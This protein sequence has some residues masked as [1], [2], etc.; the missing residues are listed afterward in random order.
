MKKTILAFVI[1]GIVNGA[2]DERGRV[3]QQQQLA[4]RPKARGWGRGRERV[5]A[6]AEGGGSPLLAHHRVH[7]QHRLRLRRPG[8]RQRQGPAAPSL[9]AR[10]TRTSP[11]RPLLRRSRRAQDDAGISGPV[12]RR[13]V[14]ERRPRLSRPLPDRARRHEQ[15]PGLLERARAPAGHAAREH[16]PR[17]RGVARE[18]R[19]GRQVR[20]VEARS[21][22]GR[23]ER[24]LRE[25]GLL[26]RR[27]R[28]R[29]HRARPRRVRELRRR[30]QPSERV[31][32]LCR[33]RQVDAR[34]RRRAPQRPADCEP[35][36][37]GDHHRPL[38][39]RVH[40]ALGALALSSSMY[41]RRGHPRGRRRVLA[42]RISQRA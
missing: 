35:L 37:A 29:G 34:R 36:A 2:G 16:A 8:G 39:G 7:R 9:S 4:G 25:S 41:A 5:E 12:Q 18:P 19:A 40:G 27:Q 38:A 3:L 23:R 33:R 26:A 1:V 32:R 20:A 22:R 24:R 10:T 42:A 21:G 30:E 14:H 11:R 13:G 15:L 28:V 17:R 31:C 6:G